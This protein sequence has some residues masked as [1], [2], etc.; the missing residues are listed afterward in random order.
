[1]SNFTLSRVL[2]AA[3]A[4][5]SWIGFPILASA[6]P[7]VGVPS[8]LQTPLYVAQSTTAP[9]GTYTGELS[10]TASTGRLTRVNAGRPITKRRSTTTS[11]AGSSTTSPT[12]ASTISMTINSFSSTTELK[13]IAAATSGNLISTL[14]AYQ[15]GTVTIDGGSYTINSATYRPGSNGTTIIKLISGSKT[16]ATSSTSTISGA[17]NTGAV[18]ELTVPS[19]GGVGS[20][21][22]YQS[23][24]LSVAQSG[25][26]SAQAGTTSATLLANVKKAQ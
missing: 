1:M 17:K 19:A 6:V 12:A 18:I 10:A 24:Q 23:V 11:P 2:P 3:F 25:E 21:K 22:F 15:H 13:A 14:N 4:V 26:I 8:M 7:L 9:T 16:A 5:T 20:G